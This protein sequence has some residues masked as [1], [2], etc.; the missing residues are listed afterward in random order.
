MPLLS[1]VVKN[2]QK[3]RFVASILVVTLTS[4]L[5]AYKNRSCLI[6]YRQKGLACSETMFRLVIMANRNDCEQYKAKQIRKRQFSAF[7]ALNVRA[8]F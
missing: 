5:I 6:A 4:T 1:S 7:Q 8:P 3:K 2:V